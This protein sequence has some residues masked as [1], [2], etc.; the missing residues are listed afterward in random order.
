MF[1]AFKKAKQLVK[2][3]LGTP[4]DPAVL[5]AEIHESFDSATDQLLKEAKAILENKRD[6]TSGKRLMELGFNSAKEAVMASTALSR[7]EKSER[8]A[9]NIEYYSLHY[10]NNKFINDAKVKELCNKY[11]LVFGDCVHYKGTVPEKNIS[12]MENFKLRQE[13][14]E[15]RE[16]G[17]NNDKGS[18]NGAYGYYRRRMTKW[19]LMS[20]F[21]LVEDE[22]QKYA[23][24]K[25]SF[26]VCAPA[27]DFNLE[28]M[29]I[30]DGY[31]L[32]LNIPDPVV[33][34]PVP[35]G[36]LIVTKWGLEASDEIVVNE[37]HN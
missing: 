37:K 26:M 21:F 30:E 15:K 14:V 22:T 25:V 24:E 1:N 5:I 36:Y 9:K 8:L 29:Q 10:P 27:K 23:Y 35:G 7:Q 4:K 33:L 3:S 28:N 6:E 32:S 31:K 19:G 11:G 12:E 34:Q 20:T 17:Y 16:C 13:D 18:Y 2:E